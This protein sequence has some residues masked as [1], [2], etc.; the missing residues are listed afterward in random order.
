[1]IGFEFSGIAVSMVGWLTLKAL[2]HYNIFSQEGS[3]GV[4][5]IKKR[6]RA[7]LASMVSLLFGAIGGFVWREQLYFWPFEPA[8]QIE[9]RNVAVLVL[10]VVA[11]FLLHL[12]LYKLI[13][14]NAFER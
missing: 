4:D 7:M 14:K 5:E 3:I 13:T 2:S 8:C 11:L 6:Y 10:F 9:V 1:M 12:V